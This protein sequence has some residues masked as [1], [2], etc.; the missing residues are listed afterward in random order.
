MTAKQLL[1][2]TTPYM[3][4]FPALVVILLAMLFPV[5]YGLGLSFFEWALRDIRVAP[6]FRGLGNYVELFKSEYFYTN[7]RVTLVFTLT[8]TVAEIA[9]GLILALLLEAKMAGLR[10]FRTI[11]VL[12]I[13]VA[14]VV[15]GVVW[16]YLYDPSFGMINY[17]LNVLG[18][19]ARMWLSEPNLALP[20]IIIADIW[21]WT[22]FVFLL[23]LAGL[24]GVPKDMLEAGMIDGTN[25]L[26]NLWHIKLPVIQSLILVTAA[27]RLIDAFRSLV[28]VYIMTF[29]GPGKSTELLSI[30][31][32]KTAFI[33]QRL[34]LAS[35]IAVILLLIIFL[36]TLFVFFTSRGES[37][38]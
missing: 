7:V 2:R 13:M 10:T 19:E 6:V 16:R 4:L 37:R 36:V 34:G 22:P 30:A 31:V 23:L 38:R 21:Q 33:S 29:G 17:L 24:Q 28:V 14:P 12:P 8:V 9:L 18:I 3:F 20:S 1:Q 25:Y 15:V 32:Y 35:A 27:L 11:F 26:Q 5:I